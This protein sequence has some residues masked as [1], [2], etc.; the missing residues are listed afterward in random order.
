MTSGRMSGDCGE[1]GDRGHEEG[2]EGWCSMHGWD[3]RNCAPYML[4]QVLLMQ[5][6]ECGP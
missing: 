6:H 5:A 2:G 3:V 4:Q 1:E